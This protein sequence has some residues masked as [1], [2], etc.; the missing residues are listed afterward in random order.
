MPENAGQLSGLI[1]NAL[2]VIMRQRVI[3]AVIRA[4]A[5]AGGP[6]TSQQA[7]AAKASAGPVL[8]HS[9]AFTQ[10]AAAITRMGPDELGRLLHAV[11]RDRKGCARWW[12][13]VPGGDPA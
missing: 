8:G 6:V 10:A 7:R 4:Q 1:R 5:I 2:P 13:E 3:D 9:R 12:V 11:G